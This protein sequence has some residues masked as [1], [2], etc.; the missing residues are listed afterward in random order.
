MYII[1]IGIPPLGCGTHDTMV[2]DMYPVHMI[3]L[4]SLID[5]TDQCVL[6]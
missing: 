3:S 2:G 4:A 5:P 6:T 1:E